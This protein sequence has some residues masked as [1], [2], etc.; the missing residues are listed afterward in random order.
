MTT[1]NQPMSRLS[2]FDRAFLVLMFFFC[3]GA[4]QIVS[5]ELR[6]HSIAI[7]EACGGQDND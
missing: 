6:D 3:V 2:T 7:I 5:C 1:P 4:T